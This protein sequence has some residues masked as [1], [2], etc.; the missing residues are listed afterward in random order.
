MPSFPFCISKSAFIVVA[1]WMILTAESNSIRISNSRSWDFCSF[2]SP[3]IRSEGD[4]DVA[5]SGPRVDLFSLG[6]VRLDIVDNRRRQMGF[7]SRFQYVERG[8]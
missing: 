5:I 8:I 7:R 2:R 1:D 6:S 3:Q 4:R